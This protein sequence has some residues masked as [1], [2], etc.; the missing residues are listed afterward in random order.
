MRQ[1]YS[2]LFLVLLPF[3][4]LRL[5]WKSRGHQEYRNRF[6]ERLAFYQ[7][8]PPPEKNPIWIHAV[9][10]GECEAAFLI[11]RR[12]LQKYP[13]IPLLLT[14]TTPTGSSRIRSVLGDRVAHVYL[15]FDVPWCSAAFLDHF[16]PGLGIVMETEIWPNLFWAVKSRKI[17]LFI[18]NARLSE[19]SAKGYR[20][21]KSMTRQALSAVT[22]ILAQ[23]S[24]DASR[25]L[26][27]GAE[28]SQIV[29]TGNLKYD[30]SW[31]AERAREAKTLRKDL[32]GDRPILIAGSTHPGEEAIVLEAFIGVLQKVPDCLLILAPRHPERANPVASHC[33]A[34]KISSLLRSEQRRATPD[35]QVLIVDGIGEL[36]LFYGAS[37][38]AFIGGSLI[39][40]GGQNPLEPLIQGVPVLFGPNMNNFLQPKARILGAEAGMMVLDAHDLRDSFL[41]LLLS[42]GTAMEMGKRGKEMI[43]KNQGALE[44]Q[45]QI[46]DPYLKSSTSPQS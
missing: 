15:P 39:P 12:L 45:I 21:L 19:K 46:L 22:Q 28:P 8:G 1:L 9:S 32:F 37:D 44:R 29:V 14:C 34:L 16:K 18:V 23:T 27:I 43:L 38:V 24:E 33:K 5:L 4:F 25:Y 10:V 31:N 26:S 20:R 42:P 2:L 7:K 36:R 30:L 6:S 41:K 40:H 17:P 35:E 11:V 13:D 3:M